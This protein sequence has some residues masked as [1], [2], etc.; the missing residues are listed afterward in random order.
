MIIDGKYYDEK[1][2][3]GKDALVLEILRQL[4]YYNNQPA[5]SE[6]SKG[7]EHCCNVFKEKIKKMIAEKS[8]KEKSND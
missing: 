2:P 5:T 6:F 8:A 3:F 4:E 1:E 7:F